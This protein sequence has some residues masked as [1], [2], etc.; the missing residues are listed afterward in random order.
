MDQRAANARI[1]KAT[2]L[3]NRELGIDAEDFFGSGDT[4]GTQ[5]AVFNAQIT[6]LFERGGK[7]QA[8]SD[9]APKSALPQSNS[10]APRKHSPH[11]GVTPVPYSRLKAASEPHRPP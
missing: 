10:T 11:I 1:L 8:R 9:A 7:R 2:R 5:S 3:P 6:Q 4:S